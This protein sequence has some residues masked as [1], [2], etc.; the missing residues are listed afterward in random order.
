MKEHAVANDLC[1]KCQ[2][3]A[4]EGVLGTTDQLLIVE[5]VKGHPRNL[6]VSL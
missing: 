1:D 3:E 4:Q 6:A 2:L 5:E